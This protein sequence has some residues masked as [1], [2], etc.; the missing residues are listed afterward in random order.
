MLIKF[1][2]P[3]SGSFITTE[4]TAEKIVEAISKSDPL[5]G[6]ITSSEVPRILYSLE[7]KIEQEK[8]NRSDQQK[9]IGISQRFFPLV[10]MLKRAKTKKEFVM[11][12]KV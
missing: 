12:R 1:E 2:S 6:I 9:G 5:E 11:W 10:E 8:K 4:N 7:L 3:A